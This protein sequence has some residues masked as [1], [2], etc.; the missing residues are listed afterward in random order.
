MKL[1]PNIA[2]ALGFM[3]ISLLL[4]M[5]SF[6]FAIYRHMYKATENP[7]G[8]SDAIEFFLACALALSVVVAALSAI[9]LLLK[10]PRENRIAALWL[11]LIFGAVYGLPDPLHRLAARFAI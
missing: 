7:Y 2:K 3:T 6:R 8:L 5:L 9:E 10:G 11:L 4:V 1:R